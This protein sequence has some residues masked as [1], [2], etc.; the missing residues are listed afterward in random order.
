MEAKMPATQGNR[1]FA[2]KLMFN[3]QQ[4]GW[5]ENYYVQASDLLG[6]LKSFQA[7][8]PSRAALLIPGPEL[9]AV[10]VSDFTTPGG[11]AQYYPGGGPGLPG[12]FVGTFKTNAPF[13]TGPWDAVK[14]RLASGQ[15]VH[16]TMEL[17][18]IPDTVLGTW[19][20]GVGVAN[21]WTTLLAQWTIQAANS[22]WCIRTSTGL[23]NA[24]NVTAIAVSTGAA[25]QPPAGTLIVTAPGH[26]IAANVAAKIAFSQVR[27]VPKLN[28]N[29]VGI[30]IDA[31]TFYL[32]N[33]DVGTIS[34]SGGGKVYQVVPSYPAIGNIV[35]WYSCSRRPGRPF[36]TTLGRKLH[37]V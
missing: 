24:V 18:G 15:N 2:V 5:S 27:C 25:N 28:R 14:L 33:T 3:W 22:P 17:R 31:N 29:H 34:Y 26:G 4:Q 23:A 30:G 6:A 20:N 1:P 21:A 10:R 11:G 37:K 13:H 36:G 12:P 16:R 7:M 9:Y 35:P 32:K 19:V 8:W